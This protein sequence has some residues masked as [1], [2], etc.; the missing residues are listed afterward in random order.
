VEQRRELLEDRPAFAVSG[1]TPFTVSIW[2]KAA[3]FSLSFGCRAL[4]VTVS[5]L[6]SANRRAWDNET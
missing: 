4:P 6:R 5:P 3:Y 2:S 1:S